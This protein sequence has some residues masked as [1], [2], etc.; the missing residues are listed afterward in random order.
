M[1]YDYVVVGGGTAG[2]VLAERLSA[3]PGRR[4]LLLERGGLPWHPLLHVP[5]GFALTLSDP[6]WTAGYPTEPFGPR[7]G[8]DVWLRG[9]VL[10]GSSMINGMMWN[11]GAAA[12]FDALAAAGLPEWSWGHVLAAYR[13]LEHHELGPGGGRGSGGPVHISLTRAAAAGGSRAVCE[14]VV[15]AAAGAGLTPV[16]DVNATDRERIG[17]TPATVRR[18]RRVSA[19]SAFWW[20][21]RRRPN[22]DVLT[23]VQV[24][25]VLLAG[26]AGTSVPPH[27]VGVRARRGGQVRE[28]GAAREV[29]VC[30]GALESPLLLER[31]GI[32]RPDVLAAAGIPVRVA[33]PQV[34]EH[35]L[36]HRSISVHVRLADGLGFNPG[37]TGRAGRLR[38]GARYLLTG[39]GPVGTGAYE[40][41]AFLR[42]RPG[43]PRPDVQVVIT[44]LLTDE[45]GLR[46]APGSGLMATAYLLRPVSAS[47][48]HVSGA[49]AA[50]PPRVRPRF[51]AEPA[52]REALAGALE[53]VREVLRAAPL[54]PYVRGEL[55][56]GAGVTGAEAVA[57][58]ALATGSGIYHGV[59]SARMGAAPD[60]VLD[61]RLRV[62]GVAGLRVVDAS[63]YPAM[64]A[65]NTAAPVM[66][67]AWRA[68]ELIGEDAGDR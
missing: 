3:D 53:R 16:P 47:S 13:R 54:A 4:V 24:E 26:A 58:H 42:S 12:D 33:S 10:G 7:G 39:G 37:L 60:S 59:G 22:L 2:C 66:A 49:G 63:A 31:S 17:Y 51:L 27:A 55:A 40:L 38:A 8:S 21:A 44:P 1:R 50:D 29:L 6:R 11:R 64:V 46:V 28:I 67:L 48:V 43:L 65:G 35:L 61:G 20:P 62:R 68:A 45:T 14:A 36:E 41:M 5:K 34:G 32:G 30:A 15:A 52:E 19:A 23:G 9:R 56:P 18:G 57:A 25:R